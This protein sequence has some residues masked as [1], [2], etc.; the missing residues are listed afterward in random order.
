MVLRQ[1]NEI[2]PAIHTGNETNIAWDQSELDDVQELTLVSPFGTQTPVAIKNQ[3]VTTDSLNVTGVYC[4]TAAKSS[5]LIAEKLEG[6]QSDLTPE[7]VFEKYPQQSQLITVNLCSSDESDLRLPE[8]PEQ[9]ERNI[10][11][12]GWPTWLWAVLIASGFIVVEWGLFHRRVV[13]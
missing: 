5:E 13:A 2:H 6:V 8:L 7:Q 12:S 3:Q 10:P 9:S 4:L 1:S 11:A